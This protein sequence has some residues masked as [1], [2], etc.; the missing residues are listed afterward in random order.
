MPGPLSG[1]LV[2]DFTQQLA[3]PGAT[4]LLG[5]MGAEIIHVEPPPDALGLSP[6]S[7]LDPTGRQRA[8]LVFNRNKKSISVDL[9]SEAGAEIVRRI[10]TRADVCVN[11]FRPGVAERLGVDYERIR[12]IRPDIVYCEISSFGFRGTERRR[13]GFDIIAQAGGG[14]MIPDWQK[15]DLPAPLPVPIG[16]VTSMCLA[17]LG[18]VA[19]LHHRQRTGE[20]QKVQTSMLDGVLLQSILR[21]VSVE[22]TDATWRAATVEGMGDIVRSGGSFA[23]GS[24]VGATGIGGLP[25][26]GATGI[27]IGVYYR[28]YR[29][30]DGFLAVGCLN[31]GQ[32]RRLNEA[33]ELGDP[34]FIPGMDLASPE[35]A[36]AALQL[37][38]R[39]EAAF[40][41]RTTEDWIDELDSRSIACGRVL[42]LLEVFDHPHHLAN[43]MVIT[44][45]D[46]WLGKVKTLGH[47][48]KFGNTPMS[49][50]S[51][52][53]PVGFDT[54]EI[55]G[56]LGYSGPQIE[57]LIARSIVCPANVPWPP[58]EA[59]SPGD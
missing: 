48:I 15:P 26:D 42:S 44:Q 57:D 13:V 8:A 32:Q 59:S 58:E 2:L 47:P 28:S 24:T 11:N 29:T 18:I 17:A 39:A 55:L 46:P 54:N 45:D 21:M 19:A 30:A 10:A 4:M 37:A 6:A 40:A 49:V 52:T 53:S 9:T 23:T 7:A 27:V 25:T 20:G 34:R 12:K 5:D 43:Q 51:V 22:S 35:A 56:S 36:Q 3:G 31:V 16:D 50:R 33:L 14:A 1:V 38:P 41:T